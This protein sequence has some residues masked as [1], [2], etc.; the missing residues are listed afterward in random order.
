MKTRWESF[1][2]ILLMLLPAVCLLNSGTPSIAPAPENTISLPCSSGTMPETSSQT[3]TSQSEH[4]NASV[5]RNSVKPAGVSP[6]SSIQ[7]ETGKTS[8]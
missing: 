1:V 8:K 3:T 6:G 4:D 7:S 5:R 2:F